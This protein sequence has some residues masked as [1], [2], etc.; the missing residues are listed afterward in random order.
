MNH[1]LS[2]KMVSRAVSETSCGCAVIG[3]IITFIVMVVGVAIYSSA[4]NSCLGVSV[5][6][7]NSTG[8]LFYNDVETRCSV[9]P[10]AIFYCEWPTS[11]T[12][13]ELYHCSTNGRYKNIRNGKI[14]MCVAVLILVMCIA[15]LMISSKQSRTEKDMSAQ[16]LQ[17]TRIPV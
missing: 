13:P 15:A 10:D 4:P 12:C 9:K 11:F 6:S 2:A 3:L 14:L 16:E 7:A 17:E 1:T 8:D 5:C